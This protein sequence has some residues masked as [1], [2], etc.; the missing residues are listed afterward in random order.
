MF[1][2]FKIKNRW[3]GFLY[4]FLDVAKF[5]TIV[6]PDGYEDWMNDSP[7]KLR[8]ARSLQQSQVNVSNHRVKKTQRSTE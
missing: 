6:H 5:I 4:L 1:N 3:F 8:R 2:N 7:I